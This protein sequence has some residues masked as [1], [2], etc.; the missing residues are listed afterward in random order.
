MDLLAEILS[1]RDTT[2]QT[3]AWCF[4]EIAQ[5]PEIYQKIRDEAIAVCGPTGKATYDK[6][7]DLKYATA[8]F[9]ETLRL[10]PNVPTSQ[11]LA[12]QD[13]VLP[14]TGT[15]VYAG[16]R[17]QWSSYC[18]C[19]WAVAWPLLTSFLGMGR[20]PAIWGP[21]CEVFKVSRQ[22]FYASKVG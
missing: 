13:C 22:C 20:S 2:A 19:L 18:R 5:H 14:G 10:H 15:Q 7:K 8:V 6:L 1:G 21:D 11:K 16:Q 4:W 3:L 12:L 17:M 9:N